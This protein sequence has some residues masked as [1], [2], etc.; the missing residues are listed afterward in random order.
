MNTPHSTP[1]GIEA[2]QLGRHYDVMPIPMVPEHCVEVA[3]GPLTF[4]VESRNL[5]DEAI[6][7][8]ALDRGRPDQTFDSG[9]DD[10]GACVHVLGAVDG[11]EWL[12]FDCFDNEPHYHYVRNHE[13]SNQVIRFDQFAEGDPEEWTL[14]RLR[15]N[16]PAMLAYAGAQELADA[17]ATADLSSAVDEVAVLLE[18]LRQA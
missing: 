1:S 11:A 18:K 4:V 17:V 14:Q 13:Q 9:I 12:R 6:N 7:L 2:Y 3:A 10:S 16:L 15:T 8:N 5:S